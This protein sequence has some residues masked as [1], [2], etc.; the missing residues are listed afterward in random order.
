[1]GVVAWTAAADQRRSRRNCTKVQYLPHPRIR[2]IRSMAVGRLRI[3]VVDDE[4]SVRKALSRFVRAL[5]FEVVGF[6]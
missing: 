1:M 6:A 4:V 2:T 3:A 5:K